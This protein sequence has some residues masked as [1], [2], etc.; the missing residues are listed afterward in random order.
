MI[1]VQ[2]EKTEP[3]KPLEQASQEQTFGDPLAAATFLLERCSEGQLKELRSG[4]IGQL[5]RSR[6]ATRTARPA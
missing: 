2:I 4:K 3:G 1:R 6:R 5:I